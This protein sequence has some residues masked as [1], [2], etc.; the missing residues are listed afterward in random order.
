MIRVDKCPHCGATIT[1][2]NGS[3]QGAI[4]DPF[5]MCYHC[6]KPYLEK[7]CYE[8]AVA[9]FYQKLIA[10]NALG[11]NLVISVLIAMFVGIAITKN[12]PFNNFGLIILLLTVIFDSVITFINYLRKTEE[13]EDSRKRCENPFYVLELGAVGHA[14]V[15]SEI[16][17]E[18][19][20]KLRNVPDFDVDGYYKIAKEKHNEKRSIIYLIIG[21]IVV[22]A[23]LV[24]I[25]T[26][27]DNVTKNDFYSKT[28]DNKER[29][30]SY[31]DAGNYLE[32]INCAEEYRAIAAGIE[33]IDGEYYKY[34]DEILV[35]AVRKSVCGVWASIDKPYR[36]YIFTE[37]DSSFVSFEV[38]TYSDKKELEE[39][40]KG[41]I[42]EYSIQIES[43]SV[44]RGASKGIY[45]CI[46]KGGD[47]F[48]VD[49]NM[50]EDT[51]TI[52]E[53]EYLRI[54]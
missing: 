50:K 36:I 35:N 53:E 14:N 15:D 24:L 25:M 6:R 54:K 43:V 34:Y 8:Y 7:N 2:G 48:G 16:Y 19:L 17:K 23:G 40:A 38:E 41:N 10:L 31:L 49:Y 47:G 21:S 4:G 13:I 46:E 27:R 30:E 5:T 20:L 51:I 26:I 33:G 28:E 22:I 3:K 32:A 11:N 12:T 42:E 1:I 39:I 9:Y 45:V 52:K 18:A 29:I 44:W 37:D